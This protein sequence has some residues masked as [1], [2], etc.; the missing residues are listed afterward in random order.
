MNPSH[1]LPL[2]F[3][4]ISM[5]GI[6]LPLRAQ[7]P[8]PKQDFLL[9]VPHTH[10]EGAVFKTREE[11]L[12]IG[13]PHIMKVLSLLQRY[14][15]YRYVLD[16][17]AYVRPFLERYPAE[18]ATFKKMLN[19]HRL[20]IAGG[21]VVMEDENVPSGES[22]AHQFLLSKWFFRDRLGYE[23]RAGWGL[24]TFGH[25]AQMPQILKLA[26]M[27]S[28]WFSRGVA[29]SQT[30][31]EVTWQGIDGTT[32]PGHWLP[33]GYSPLDEHPPSFQNFEA[34][35]RSN[36]D[37]LTP[38]SNGPGR[39]LFAG[40]DVSD[41]D[42]TLPL[43]VDQWNRT[44]SEPFSI[45]L[46]TPSDFESLRVNPSGRPV[47]VGDLNPVFQGVYSTRIE[48]KRWMRDMERTLTSAE[49][50]SVLAGRTS[51]ADRETIE[52]AWEPVL[53][54]QTH[55]LS[56][57]VMLDH[58]YEDTL[59]G[60]RFSKRLGDEILASDL[61]ALLSKV[62]TQGPG[63]PLAVFNFLGWDRSDYV[64]AEVG[65][66]QPKVSGIELEDAS[67]KAVPVQV[68][69][70]HSNG[71]D[72][73]LSTATI[74][75]IARDVPAMGY[76]IY[77]VIPVLPGAAPEASSHSSREESASRGQY[78]ATNRDDFGSMENEFY[79]ATVNLWTGEITSLVLKRNRWEVLSKPGNIV[80]REE[81]RGDFWELYGTLAADRWTTEK[82]PIG[83]PR[84]EA[85]EWSN[86]YVGGGGEV[87]PGP[88][89]T[90][91]SS[92]HPF[93]RNQFDTTIRMYPGIQ[94]IDIHTEIV[95]MEPSVRYRVLFPTTIHDGTNT[96]EIAF[97]AVERALHQEFPAQN[98]ADYSSGGRGLA[99]LNRGLP[100]NN[101]TDDTMMVSLLRSTRLEVYG[102]DDSGF[103]PAKASESDTALELGK[104]IAH[105]YALVPHVGSWQDAQIFRAGLEFNNPL[106][107]RNIDS[108]AG[109]MP[110]QWGL[111]EISTPDVVVSALKPSRDSEIALRVYEAAGHS[112]Q[113]AEVHFA[114]PLTSAR[115]A[116]LIE[117]P[118]REL[119]SQG[120]TISFDLHPYEIKTFR[121]RFAAR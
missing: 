91:F 106:V 68:L 75:F 41:P 15:Q 92:S 67:G 26:E 95:N 57:G 74:A 25:N 11:Y 48:L 12:Q 62:D 28:Y 29:G 87:K 52:R 18:V 73:G 105:D 83:L 24:D 32:V 42:E 8:D 14:P 100:G 31:A 119:K 10:W 9:I 49:K 109:A 3:L 64:E 118:G 59:A 54:N 5:L 16:Q 69:T 107:A 47:I 98:W 116:N 46:G 84:P 103:D 89:V 4:A 7:S 96:Q 17:M 112:V 110:K 102:A 117:D 38:F 13:L 2:S 55:D 85:T 20:E 76:T 6:V 72:G 99:V 40:A 97:G 37:A 56:S 77:H 113:H 82:R 65:F 60:Y 58:V 79:K 21:T 19:E 27:N 53:F 30:P 111:L 61:D 86:N 108:H 104:R 50:A 43:N 44:K 81:D 90:Q 71:G 39:V 1:W 120:N 51:T 94:R 63:A 36:F 35:I 66:S 114:L 78:S 23:V 93:G 80:A 33:T 121:L 34:T 45:Q 88:V 70:S 22:I 101:V 115:E